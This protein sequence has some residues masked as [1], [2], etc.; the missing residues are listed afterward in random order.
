MTK[1][2]TPS[3]HTETLISAENAYRPLTDV[4]HTP[5][6]FIFS[7][8]LPGV[9]QEDIDLEITEKHVL[10]LKAKNSFQ[11]PEGERHLKQFALGH[12]YRAF[13]LGD[14]I[15]RDQVTARLEH[16]ILQVTVPKQEKARPKRILIGS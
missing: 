7:F 9:K 5:E 10:V 2:L 4:S 14:Q 3:P 6:A 13:E 15:E 11:T 12:Y 1:A 16:G 8:A